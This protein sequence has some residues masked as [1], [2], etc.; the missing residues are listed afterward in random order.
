MDMVAMDLQFRRAVPSD[1]EEAIPLIYSSGPHEGDYVCVVGRHTT[2][3]F[4]RI[5]FVGVSNLYGCGAHAVAVLDGHVVGIGAFRNG[6]K[7]NRETLETVGPILRVYGPLTGL[8]VF[9]RAMHLN[10]LMPPPKKDELI[11]QDLGVREDMRGKGIG[12]ALLTH[13]IE[14]ARSQGFRRCIL[15]VAV[16]NPRAQALYERLGF[17]VVKERKWHIKGSAVRVPDQRRM[18]LTM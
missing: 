10:K 3:D 14:L 4:L 16:T 8:G 2:V 13:Q 18:E 9:R 7:Y 6:A 11:I 17:R 1:V 12:T 5:A 15:D